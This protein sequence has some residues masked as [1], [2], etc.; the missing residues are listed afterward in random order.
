MGDVD[1]DEQPIHRQA[2]AP[3]VQNQEGSTT[4]MD[5]D[6]PEECASGGLPDLKISGAEL[7]IERPS[8][9]GDPMAQAR[10]WTSSAT[11]EARTGGTRAEPSFD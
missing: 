8:I 1:I 11:A 2:Y 4:I 7:Y 3:V 5:K 9:G 10:G 6:V